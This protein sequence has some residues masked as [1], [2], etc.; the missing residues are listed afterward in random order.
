MVALD[1]TILVPISASEKIFDKQTNGEMACLQAIAS[2]RHGNT[3]D[4]FWT[5]TTKRR[6]SCLGTSKF[7]GYSPTPLKAHLPGCHSV[8]VGR[9]LNFW[10]SYRRPF[11]RR[12][13]ISNFPFF[14]IGLLMVPVVIRLHANR[15]S[16]TERLLY[17][18]WMGGVFFVSNT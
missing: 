8:V 18:D 5:G 2:C 15:A 12:Y 1:A 3:I 17:V 11:F 14:V 6:P 4:S 13:S 9:R 7:D 10:A 16:V